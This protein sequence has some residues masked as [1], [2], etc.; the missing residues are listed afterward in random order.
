MQRK[1]SIWRLAPSVATE[2]TGG[3]GYPFAA[4]PLRPQS[5]AHCHLHPGWAGCGLASSFLPLKYHQQMPL[6]NTAFPCPILAVHS[7]S[8]N[9]QT[10]TPPLS[11]ITTIKADMQ[12]NSSFRMTVLH[13]QHEQAS[14]TQ[15]QNCSEYNWWSMIVQHIYTLT[16]TCIIKP[17]K[18]RDNS[19]FSRTTWANQ[20]H[21]GA[22]WD[23]E[24]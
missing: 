6:P 8:A 12:V 4:S 3:I 23:G 2:W 10:P 20:R 17:K 16:W 5:A 22:C 11:E 15:T 19:R 7:L 21:D 13:K 24:G 14:L 9:H 18:E 1:G